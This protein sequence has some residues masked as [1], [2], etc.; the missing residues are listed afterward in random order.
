MVAL[1]L[2][3]AGRHCGFLEMIY[4]SAGVREVDGPFLEP[5]SCHKPT[6]Y[7]C[8]SSHLFAEVG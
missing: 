8:G 4:L 7:W 5:G 2:R 6:Q 3:R 1:N